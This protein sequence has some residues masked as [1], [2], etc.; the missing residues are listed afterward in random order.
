MLVF[1][2]IRIRV[3]LED[4]LGEIDWGLGVDLSPYRNRVYS[5][6]GNCLI[7]F[8]CPDMLGIEKSYRDSDCCEDVVY[9]G[10]SRL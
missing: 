2:G 4:R 6:I 8:Y 7:F 9:R 10:I 1:I 5:I 3:F